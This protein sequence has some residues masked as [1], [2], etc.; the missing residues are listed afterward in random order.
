M[1]RDFDRDSCCNK[2]MRMSPFTAMFL[3]M[4]GV[5]MTLIMGITMIALGAIYTANRLPTNAM[6]MIE[7]IVDSVP[8]LLESLPPVLA[9]SFNDRRLTSYVEQLDVSASWNEAA[10]RFGAPVIKVVNRGRETVSL[11]SV[12][13]TALDSNGQYL[14]EWSETIATPMSLGE[15]VRG[16]ILPGNERVAMLGHRHERHHARHHHRHEGEP[17][18]MKKDV[19]ITGDVKLKI[20]VTDVRV[21]NG[22][23]DADSHAG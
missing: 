11:L 21:W 1:H 9:D 13:I 23:D 16:P 17:E 15:D 6:G 14:G 4:G 20:E 5:V 8:E 7:K 12:H 19:R 10:T 2:K 3:A 18:P 22:A